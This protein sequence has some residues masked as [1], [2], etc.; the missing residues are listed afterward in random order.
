MW[1]Q[2]DHGN[3]VRPPDYSYRDQLV[4]GAFDDED[5]DDGFERMPDVVQDVVP[6]LAHVLEQSS[7]EHE[8]AYDAEIQRAMQESE[9]A[10]LQQACR[11]SA[12][13]S[14]LSHRRFLQLATRDPLHS[15][16]RD[17]ATEFVRTGAW[18]LPLTLDVIDEA[19]TNN[20]LQD[21]WTQWRSAL[22]PN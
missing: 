13:D 19:M 3:P 15:A 5:D 21:E 4:P 10:L 9:D 7:R 14:L 6:D 17:A 16:L 18:T 20:K 22:P 8:A 1:G 2:D 11:Q 12:C